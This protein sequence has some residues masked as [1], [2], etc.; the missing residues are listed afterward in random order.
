MFT[1]SQNSIL[2]Y[3]TMIYFAFLVGVSVWIGL[4]KIRTYDD[5][6]VASRNVSIYPLILT[7]VGT[8][9][10]GSTL[11]GFMT[12]GYDLGMRE[13]WYMIAVFAFGV[14]MAA[15]MVKRIRRLGEKYQYVTIGDVTAHRFGNH[16]RVPTTISV[17]TAYAAITGM[18]FIAIGL[19]L[20]LVA[21]VP[22]TLAIVVSA[23]ML[24]L[25]TVFGGLKAVIWQDAVHGTIQTLA[26]FGLF[27]AVTVIAGDTST[28]RSNAAAMGELGNLDMMNIGAAE[29]GVYAL[30]LGAYQLVRQDLWQR[31]W[32]GKNL[33]TVIRG[34]WISI[35]VAAVTTGVVIW[36]G[37]VARYGLGIESEDSALIY[38]EVSNAIMPFEVVVVMVV[39]L[40]ATVIST[41]DS[42]F[43][44]GSSSIINDIIRP[45]LKGTPTQ[46]A[47]L[48]WSRLSVVITGV[49]A[50]GLSLA[51]TELIGLWTT[52]TAML[53][54]GL[55]F[56]ALLAL[57]AKKI[58]GR[59]AIYA[60]WA[61]LIISVGW[62]LLGSPIGH[63]VY[64]GLPASVL[65]YVIFHYLDRG[66]LV[67]YAGKPP[68]IADSSPQESHPV[69]PRENENATTGSVS[70]R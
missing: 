35:V 19:V 64:F 54:S 60:M 43:M 68:K 8:A 27:V 34:Y 49:L 21:G 15:F 52:G 39:A 53:V 50:L 5:Y 65:T 28:I 29:L 9:I 41:A 6:N 36:I 47:L 46:K 40:L 57:F 55:L 26:V 18:Q 32:A 51:V 66:R 10:G 12:T 67:E 59:G 61:G 70:K 37:V 16:A 45:L 7:Y 38:Y 48:R 24:T 11:L 69:P 42:F 30:T 25:K 14:V 62:T 33:K 4:R 56:P 20:N 63:P 2:L 58:S 1:D 22:L 44:A 13:M 31:A 3:L 17:L 23:I